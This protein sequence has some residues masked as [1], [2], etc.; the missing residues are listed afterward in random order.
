MLPEPYYQDNAVTIY[1]GDAVEL[2]PGLAAVDV[3]ITDPPYSAHVDRNVRA[4]VG[5]RPGSRKVSLGFEPLA[6]EVRTR[7]AGEFARLVAR[8]ILVFCEVEGVHLWQ[9]ALVDVG[10]DHIRTGA[11][12]KRGAPPQ[13]T[14][15]RPAQGFETIEI[16][17]QPGRKRWNG[18]GSHGVWTAKIVRGKGR[19][20]PTEKPLDLIARL[21]VLFSDPGELI[22]DPFAGA[23][24]TGAAAKALGRRAVLI[25]REERYCEAG[26]R[27]LAQEELGF[28]RVAAI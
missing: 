19:T 18:R 16:A 1:H 11:W 20:H 25:E 22:L 4:G 14:G 24:T 13:F 3:A 10:L 7:I 17:H 8:W 28:E 5:Q 21:V 9:E 15:D 27:R 2:L 6:A 23:C 12:M 26:A